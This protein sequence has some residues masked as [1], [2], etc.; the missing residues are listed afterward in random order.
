MG[1]V[2]CIYTLRAKNFAEITVSRMVQEIQ[3]ILSFTIFVKNSKWPPF[4]EKGKIFE[5]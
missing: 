1:R 5:N 3:T 2:S 4:L